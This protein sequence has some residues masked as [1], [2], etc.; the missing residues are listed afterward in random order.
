MFG[1]TMQQLS[2]QP[3]PHP[4][5]NSRRRPDP[6]VP[7]ALSILRGF[8]APQGFFECLVMTHQLQLE[9]EVR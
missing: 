6:D 7:P 1:E 3:S 5:R 9:G 2:P 8:S 4:F